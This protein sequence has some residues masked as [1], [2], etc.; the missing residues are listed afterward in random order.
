ME[1]APT[2]RQTEKASRAN[3]LP[4]IPSPQGEG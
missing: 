3:A 2:E 1:T 4:I